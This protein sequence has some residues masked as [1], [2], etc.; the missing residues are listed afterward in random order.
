M[1]IDNGH[2]PVMFSVYLSV[3]VMMLAALSG[4]WTL[5]AIG[6][7]PFCCTWVYLKL[8]HTGRRPA[9]ARDMVL[10]VGPHT[11]SRRLPFRRF[12]PEHPC[13]ERGLRAV[14]KDQA[15]N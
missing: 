9:F 8:L 5:I 13:Q 10:S 6:V 2:K 1:G 12:L 14:R 3:L 15:V 7:L 4:M 11:R